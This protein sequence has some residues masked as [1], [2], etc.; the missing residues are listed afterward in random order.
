MSWLI[1]AGLG[2][3]RGGPL[4]AIVGG[5]VQHFITKSAQKKIRRSL[6]GVKDEAGF[7]ACLVVTLTKI[8]MV[9]GHVSQDDVAL[10]HRFFINNLNYQKGDLN[11]INQVIQ[12]T[13]RVNPDLR[14][15]ME[16]YIRATQSNY[17]LLVLALS[18]Q[19]ALKGNN[20]SEEVQEGLDELAKLLNIPF[21]E[22]DRIRRNYSLEALKTP[23]T[24]LKIEPR[25]DKETIKQAYRRLAL[26]YHPD[27]AAH[28]G[29]DQ[30]QEA[31]I[32]FLEIQDAYNELEKFRGL[33][34]SGS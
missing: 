24:V 2:F 28:L 33:Q 6:P 32:K 14:P 25:A 27:K 13:R 10:I 12:E 17:K 29:E 26:Q 18:Y 31:H 11:Y 4:G 34:G 15:V 7:V 23:F 1:G 21:E 8:A 3:L 22:H 19:I 30:V 20:L 5:T 9:K 16:Q